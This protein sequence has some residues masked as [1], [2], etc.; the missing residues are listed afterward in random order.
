M[1]CRTYPGADCDTD[2]QLLV[3]TLKVRLA[4]RQHS[5]LPLNLEE[6]KEDKEC[7]LQQRWPTGLWHWRLHRMRSPQ[8][9]SG[10]VPR[11]SCWRWPEERLDPSSRKRK[12]NG[13]LM[14][15][16]QQSGK[17]EKQKAKI[18]TDIK[19]WRQRYRELRVDKQ[20]QLEGMCM[21]LE[22][23]NSKGNLKQLFQ[24]VKSMTRKFQLCLQCIL[25]ATGE[26]LTEG[27]QI[28]NRW[29]GYC[30]DLYCD[31]EGKGIEQEYWEQEPPP[32]RS[33]VA[34]A[35][36]ADSKSQSHRSWWGPS[37]T[38]SK[39]EER[40]YWTQCTE[41]VAIWETSEW[42]EEWKFSTFI[43]LTKKGDRKQCANYR[44]IALVSQVSQN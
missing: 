35:I 24:I 36:C 7:T 30:E 3:V 26:N 31:K 32:L 38:D 18:R 37:R 10:Q 29:K 27:T 16:P 21:E 20:Q 34:R 13:Y 33:E 2:H 40:Q 4:K 12:R 41:C 23:A 19:N 43:R 8:K 22:A 17:R 15:L 1:N 25:S 39:Q 28:P 44:T 9:T 14:R 42:P 5:I 6:L 11:Q